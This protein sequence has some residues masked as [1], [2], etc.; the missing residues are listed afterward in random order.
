LTA[1]EVSL[2]TAA[3]LYAAQLMINDCTSGGIVAC[4]PAPYELFKDAPPLR[5]GD[6]DSSTGSEQHIPGW[7]AAEPA[8]CNDE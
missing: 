7:T 8:E 5:P 1:S 6:D 4:V 2:S 3:S